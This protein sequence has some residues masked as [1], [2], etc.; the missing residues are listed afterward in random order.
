MAACTAPTC[1]AGTSLVDGRCAA[2]TSADPTTPALTCSGESADCDGDPSNGCEVN[3]RD[4]PDHCGACGRTCAWACGG[5]MCNDPVQ[6]AAG[7]EHTCM[8]RQDGTVW[9]W[10]R[11]VNPD[12]KQGMLGDGSSV[13]QRLFPVPVLGVDGQPLR[14]VRKISVGSWHGCALRADSTLHCWGDNGFGKL[15]I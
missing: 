8:L 12:S 6:V 4:N 7:G 3:L 13:A 5:L 2:P 14:D 1:P 10:G 15:G 9:C 11:N